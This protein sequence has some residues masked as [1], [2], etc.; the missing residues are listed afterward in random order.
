MSRSKLKFMAIIVV[1]V[2]MAIGF[3]LVAGPNIIRDDRITDIGATPALGRGYTLSTN[4][5]Q[6]MCLKEV[7]ITEPSYDFTYRFINVS[8]KSGSGSSTTT[9]N[10]KEVVS[11]Q[12]SK[13]INTA[14]ME[15]LRRIKQKQ[16]T[17]TLVG[18]EN[19]TFQSIMA[20]IDMD[21]YYASV[22]ESR[23]PLSDSAAKLLE[24]KDI[25]GFFNA[26]GTYYVR[27][28]NRNAK[29]ICVFNALTKST[30]S[31]E[32][33]KGKLE[34]MV[35]GFRANLVKQTTVRTSGAWFWKKRSA[36][37]TSRWERDEIP[38]KTVEGSTQ[39]LS[40]EFNTWATDSRLT[41]D[42]AGF[43]I[44]KNEDA[45]LIATD[46]TTFM[47]AITQ[48]FKSMQNPNTGKVVSIEVVPWVENSEFQ[49]K[50]GI[51]IEEPTAITVVDGKLTEQKTG[52]KIL[53]YEKKLNL[54]MN[55]EYM[56]ELERHDRQML[57]NFYK[58]K[59]C[60]GWIESNYMTGPPNAKVLRTDYTVSK[61]INNKNPEN[62]KEA[63]PILDLYKQLD[64]TQ[65]DALFDRAKEY[66]VGVTRC[67]R[68]I[69]DNKMYLKTYR[70]IPVC[71]LLL[72][73]LPS[74]NV[75]MTIENYCMPTLQGAY[76]RSQETIEKMKQGGPQ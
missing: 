52:E 73:N 39:G 36:E 49:D 68:G 29:F 21:T 54:N 63:I 40:E 28:L 8:E 50:A 34:E 20:I 67:I 55:G 58:A 69:V 17:K 57:N 27:S 53:M 65:V 46:T 5:F 16:G 14:F 10:F 25:P 9:E 6:S 4:T 48:A 24:K 59:L 60:R 11:D 61:L 26:C 12:T 37:T 70:E 35:K 38:E 42:I 62:D 32:T 30:E 56:A 47:K 45:S 33:F 76:S 23:T 41:I 22:D 19:R 43:G 31:Q 72:R 74:V 13:V 2:A 51:E 15:E 44:G 18:K 66:R 1:L 64:P 75:D 7:Q 3:Q 71:E